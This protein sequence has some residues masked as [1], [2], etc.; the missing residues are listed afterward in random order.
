[1]SRRS[2]AA[3]ALAGSVLLAAPTAQAAGP[4]PAQLAK[5]ITAGPAEQVEAATRS[6]LRL[7]GVATVDG[8]TGRPVVKAAAPSSGFRVDAAT[9]AALGL[10][11]RHRGDDAT[12]TLADLAALLRPAGATPAGLGRLVRELAV[13]ARRHRTSPYA[14][15]PRFLAEMARR[16]EPRIDLTRRFDPGELRLSSLE[17]QV[18]AATIYR[19]RVRTG[20]RAAQTDFPAPCSDLVKALNNWVPGAGDVGK[21]LPAAWFD[22]ALKEFLGIDI[23]KRL[24]P[25]LVKYLPWVGAAAKVAAAA[26]WFMAVQPRLTV[27]PV[28][29]HKLEP[30][31]SHYVKVHAQVGLSDAEV[32]DWKKTIGGKRS[33]FLDCLRALDVPIPGFGPENF[34]DMKDW[35][36]R[37][38]IPARAGTLLEWSAQNPPHVPGRTEWPLVMNG[39]YHGERLLALD[40]HRETPSEHEGRPHTVTVPVTVEVMARSS[41]SVDDF[42]GGAPGMAAAGVIAWLKSNFAPSATENLDVS[43]GHQKDCD[44]PAGR[45]SAAAPR[46]ALGVYRGQGKT[47]GDP[48]P[49]NE[50]LGAEC[51]TFRLSFR[52]TKTTISAFRITSLDWRCEAAD[53][54]DKADPPT[55]VGLPLMRQPDGFD[56]PILRHNGGRFGFNRDFT[57]TSPLGPKQIHYALKGELNGRRAKG[58][59]NYSARWRG[60][61]GDPVRCTT[62]TVNWTAVRNR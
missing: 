35:L 43:W 19:G 11:A 36:L 34:R 21:R 32:E 39:D 56:R 2:L 22:R 24:G 3:L 15:G 44:T 20:A 55:V 8:A 28:S 14:F 60:L 1:V 26:P 18:L 54:L 17:I 42:L 10:E 59:I 30:G 7:A 61:S 41:L 58:T 27:D 33:T 52:A 5:R 53:E 4:S 48:D 6:A 51:D 13:G 47:A 62:G 31:E 49:E 38:T 45:G 37:F 29:V 25:R 50:R 12:V 46:F 16:K 57:T 9:A 40:V 23:E